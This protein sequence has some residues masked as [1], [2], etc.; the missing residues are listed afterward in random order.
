[1][2]LLFFFLIFTLDYLFFAGLPLYILVFPFLKGS[3]KNVTTTYLT[4]EGIRKIAKAIFVYSILLL[5]I[6]I[7]HNEIDLGVRQIFLLNMIILVIG[8]ELYSYAKNDFKLKGYRYLLIVFGVNSVVAILQSLQ[9]DYFWRLPETIGA[10]F[11]AGFSDNKYFGFGFIE[12][13]RVR[14]LFLFV[15]KFSP[16]IIAGCIFFYYRGYQSKNRILLY[17]LATVML[18]V[19]IL[20]QTRSIL[21]GFLLGVIIST[22]CIFK[23][24]RK[25]VLVTVGFFIFIIGF[26]SLDFSKEYFERLYNFNLSTL[27]NNDSYRLKGVMY[28][29]EKFIDNPVIGDA[30]KLMV[31]NN[32]SVTV[33][34]V[35]FRI[36]GDYG[37]LGILSYLIMI[38]IIMSQF[39]KDNSQIFKSLLTVIFSIFFVDGLTHSSSFMFYDVFQFSFLMLVYGYSKNKQIKS[40]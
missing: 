24:R 19:A 6:S 17:A 36:L 30:E 28:S 34:G 37:I 38:K 40:V 16:A 25:K 27:A 13:N 23:N 21:V 9:M 7:F 3:I 26:I 32:E 22:L 15:H 4:D 11:G 39:L 33:H 1:M 18:F 35:I 5:G 14:G 10:M 8:I 31:D 12:F 2:R 29:I 20:T